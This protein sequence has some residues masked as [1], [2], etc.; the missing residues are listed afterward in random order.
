MAVKV[1]GKGK[2]A[3]MCAGCGGRCCRLSVDLTTF[4]IARIA[5]FTGKPAGDFMHLAKAAPDD[6]FAL[7]CMGDSLKAVMKH[8]PD[9][10]CV[11][12]NGDDARGCDIEGVKPATCLY[13]PFSL[14][15]GNPFIRQ[16]ALCP[17]ENRRHADPEKM[18]AAALGDCDWEDAFYKEILSDWNAQARGGESFGEFFK[19]AGSEIELNSRPLGRHIRKVIRWVRRLGRH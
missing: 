6:A 5:T 16:N 9:G 18:S 10:Y 2:T 12:Y 4:D 11:F 13:Y 17:L 8:K 1:S 7:R 15:G 19:F 14:Y 3:S